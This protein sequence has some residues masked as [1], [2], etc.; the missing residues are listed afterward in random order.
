MTS[1]LERPLKSSKDKKAPPSIITGLPQVNLLP[2][3][4]RAARGLQSIKRWLVVALLVVVALCAL[5]WLYA[6]S[7]ASTAQADLETAQADTARLTLEQGKYAEVPKVKAQ[8]A[9]AQLALQ[10]GGATDVEW[11]S[12]F[13]AITAVLPDDLSIDSFGMLG[14]TPMAAPE[15]STDPLQAPSVGQIAFGA[16]S[17]TVPDSAALIEGL[18]SIPG[19][20]DAFVT[21]VAVNEDDVSGVFYAIQATVQ[22]TTDA[23]SHRFDPVDPSTDDATD[24]SK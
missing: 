2:P 4:V 16:R 21:S 10:I 19:F 20:S 5:A 9:D 8:L 13:D 22:Y 3:E 1:L 11:R 24:E 15:V 17:A 7:V 18:N 23:Y 6:Q 14:A 12:Y